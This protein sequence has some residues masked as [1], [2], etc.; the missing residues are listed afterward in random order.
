L[1]EYDALNRTTK[2]TKANGIQEIFEYDLADRK[3]KTTEDPTGLNII[4]QYEFNNLSQMIKVIDAK[5]ITS[6][7]TNE[8]QRTY[9]TLGRLTTETQKIGTST[10]R[11]ISKEYNLVG[12]VT[13][14]TYPNG[15]VNTY[16]FDNNH[17]PNTI[18]SNSTTVATYTFNG[19][20]A[21]VTKAL[22]NTVSLNIEY[23]NRYQISKH[24]WKKSGV[25]IAGYNYGH[26]SVGNRIWSEN[27]VTANKSELFAFDNADRLTSFKTGTLNGSKTAII[28]PTYTQDWNLDQIGNWAG[29]ND[30]GVNST[31]TFS[32]THEMTQFKGITNTFD[33]NGNLTSDGVRT[34]KYDAFN[35]IIEVKVGAVILAQY[36]YD[37]F[38][39]RVMK[40]VDADLNSSFE[41]T[42]KF[43]Y[44]GFRC[45][46]ELNASD[47][48]VKEYVYGSLY[49]D[50]IILQRTGATDNYFTH[51]YRYSVTSLTNLAGNIVES[52]DYK[53]Y[54]QRTASGS[55]LTDV[56]YTGQRHDAETGLMYFKNR[57]YSVSMGQFITRDPYQKDPNNRMAMDGYHDGMSLYLG[58]FGATAADALGFWKL[59]RHEK[60]TKEA[61]KSISC[62]KKCWNKKC[63][64]EIERGLV[65]GSKEPD[66]PNGWTEFLD[67]FGWVEFNVGFTAFGYDVAGIQI[68]DDITNTL[69]YQS[70]FGNSQ[71]WHAMVSNEKSGKEIV[72]KMVNLTKQRAADFNNDNGCFSSGKALGFALHTIEDSFSR[73]HVERD[74][75]GRIKRFQGYP[76]QDSHKHGEA[77]KEDDSRE[78]SMAVKAVKEIL[79]M[80]ICQKE[81]GLK[82]ENY[83]R[84]KVFRLGRDVKLGGSAEEF[85]K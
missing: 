66:V 36:Q 67:V 52:Y 6:S 25:T 31:N 63:R 12:R 21:P 46:E 24:D 80:V 75:L 33:N 62:F 76:S 72:D 1:I 18:V 27:L 65:E 17:L 29:F 3:T 69:T 74:L 77:D 70:H 56:G 7:Y 30:N 11:T 84:N 26:D 32:N 64:E 19:V 14:L 59:D 43:L 55:G 38:N 45:I 60:I 9:N 5:D 23:N 54:G 39:R 47:S 28:T 8:V 41:T 81:S 57:Y 79:Q 71:W 61:L 85:K 82:L 20:N 10:D 49:I 51:D 22:G 40:M 34:F 35:R 53:V 4:T 37:A 50:E 83:L 68:Y 58:Y 48:L 44:D 15:R 78:Y 42:V 16:S 2:V 13:Q 73:S